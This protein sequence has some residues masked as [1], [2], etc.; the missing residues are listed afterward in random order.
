MSAA[1]LRPNI[2]VPPVTTM[3]KIATAQLMTASVNSQPVR[4]CQT[5]SVNR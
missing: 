5:G 2:C 4:S 1:R 3:K